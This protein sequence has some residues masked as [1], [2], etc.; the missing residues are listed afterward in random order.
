MSLQALML[1]RMVYNG[2]LGSR[3]LDLTQPSTL[4]PVEEETLWAVVDYNTMS[5]QDADDTIV[6]EQMADGALSSWV[7][8]FGGAD[9]FS[10]P[11]ISTMGQH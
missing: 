5:D 3:L 9:N 8:L 11:V 10:F 2:F 7:E 4:T 6:N 1:R